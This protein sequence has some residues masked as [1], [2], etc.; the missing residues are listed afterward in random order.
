MKSASQ[1]LAENIL[2]L[3]EE[4]SKSANEVSQASGVGQTTISAW[5]RKAREA[6]PTFNPR[7]DQLDAVARQFGRSV[8]DLFCEDLVRTNSGDITQKVTAPPSV[9]AVAASPKAT[10][11]L[12][13]LVELEQAGSSSPALYDAIERVIDLA[14][15]CPQKDD[16]AR[17][18]HAIE[19]DD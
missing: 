10:N 1:I 3:F 8:A 17:L 7:L 12:Q 5:L 11:I 14:A 15:P 4:T 13:R 18:K 19:S 16:Y 9:Q 6:D 2:H